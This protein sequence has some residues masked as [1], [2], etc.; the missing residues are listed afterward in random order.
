MF[1]P[2]E[3]AGCLLQLAKGEPGTR[4]ETN[5]YLSGSE[6]EALTEEHALAYMRTPAGLLL[7]RDKGRCYLLY[8]ALAPG[9]PFRVE[10]QDKPVLLSLLQRNRTSERAPSPLTPEFEKQ[11]FVFT[12]SALH[13]RRNLTNVSFEKAASLPAGCVIQPAY[14]P[15]AEEMVTIWLENLPETGLLVPTPAQAARAAEEGKVLAAFSAEGA[16]LGALQFEIS[17][18]SAT[19]EHVA[20]LKTAR[21]MGLGDALLRAWSRLCVDQNVQTQSLWV[22]QSNQAAIRFYE[23]RGFS[24]GAGQLREYLLA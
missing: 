16:L 6:L 23:N 10:K 21:G 9:E 24:V 12:Y 5:L 1:C 20:V 18:K 19:L 15:Q 22:V 13:M 4:R 7:L 3:D 11:G 2:V 8:Y 14:P 17:G